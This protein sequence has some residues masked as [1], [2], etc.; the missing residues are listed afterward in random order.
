[1]KRAGLWEHAATVAI[2]VCG[3]VLSIVWA[4]TVPIFEN[5]DEGAHF[6]YVLGLRTAG[7]LLLAREGPATIVDS[8][9]YVYFEHAAGLD[10][11]PFHPAEHVLPGYG[12]TAWID[13]IDSGAPPNERGRYEVPGHAM[14]SLVNVYPPGYY[15]LA[16][17]WMA[18]A[19]HVRPGLVEGFFSVRFLST[20]LFALTLLSA[21]SLMRELRIDSPT[22]LL[23]LAALALFPFCSFVSASVQPDVLVGLLLTVLAHR[24]V[25]YRRDPTQANALQAAAL[26]TACCLVKPA[27]TLPGLAIFVLVAIV[28]AVLQP[29]FT[30]RSLLHIAPAAIGFGLAYAFDRFVSYQP[31]RFAALSVQPGLDLTAPRN[32]LAHGL[33]PFVAYAFGTLT[34]NIHDFFFD[35]GAQVSYWG[36]FGWLDAPL[37][38]FFPPLEFWAPATAFAF[39]VV[40]AGLGVLAFAAVAWRCAVIARRSPRRALALFCNDV[41][42]AL[43]LF[44]DALMLLIGELM[45]NLGFQGRYWYPVVVVSTIASIRYGPRLV[46][47]VAQRLVLQRALALWLCAWSLVTSHGAAHTIRERFYAFSE[48]SPT[49]VL[50]VA[51]ARDDVHRSRR[52][53]RGASPAE[54]GE[55]RGAG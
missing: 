20:L 11:I 23:V 53:R 8:P 30:R 25:V 43:L 49:T 32:A 46:P 37:R 36:V 22:R 24:C 21:A 41:P 16:A 15:A 12:S 38:F 26:V 34:Q 51:L 1:M 35:G 33:G 13:H 52:A 28:H 2:V 54:A 9:T 40:V 39:R 5:P 31:S 50:P 17:V 6:D 7:R 44:Y 3:V 45:P 48:S 10:R 29:R 42:L 4:L 19:Q 55:G 47:F 14:P 18:L 27:Y